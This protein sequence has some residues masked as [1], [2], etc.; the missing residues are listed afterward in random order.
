MSPW[1]HLLV[2]GCSAALLGG[3]A[4][5]PVGSQGERVPPAAT[6]G[7]EVELFA[8][9]P[10]EMSVAVGRSG[11]AHVAAITASGALLHLVVDQDGR[12]DRNVLG[13]VNRDDVLDLVVGPDGTVHLLV[14][15]RYL[16]FSSAGRNDTDAG[17]CERITVT[18]AQALCSIAVDAAGVPIRLS[19]G[20]FDGPGTTRI[21]RAMKF[22]ISR[23][24]G[25]ALSTVARLEP[26]SDWDILTANI[27]A[28]R[29]GVV[30][31]LYLVDGPVSAPP[32]RRIVRLA[33]FRVPPSN[34][35]P[36]EVRGGLDVWEL[37]PGT[38]PLVAAEPLAAA[39]RSGV[40]TFWRRYGL[41]EPAADATV[42]ALARP[43]GRA[44]TML[45]APQ[46]SSAF[47]AD[48]SDLLLVR[49]GQLLRELP[50]R[51]ED[52]SWTSFVLSTL[53]A[54]AGAGRFHVVSVSKDD[55]LGFVTTARYLQII[56]EGW[57][58]PLDL[59]RVSDRVDLAKL[60]AGEDGHAFVV[61]P[62]IDG[63]VVGRWI[64]P[65]Q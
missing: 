12:V 23:F 63:R 7:R 54:A 64:T 37:V 41:P 15:T 46:S 11:V 65:R 47:L 62:A 2:L 34:A 27:V 38:E 40:P 39:A 17:G 52:A 16:R 5:A 42:I 35:R 48:A 9:H 61:L 24:E 51:S 55:L 44:Y 10:L 53:V 29:D 32:R 60:G 21:P 50:V 19:G 8:Q 6:L 36:A 22:V 20:R 4:T 57:S 26:D 33:R 58:T 31:V 1:R 13:E 43:A 25:P 45:R 30:H 59:G 3:C 14:G 18:P 56:E 28:A 49:D